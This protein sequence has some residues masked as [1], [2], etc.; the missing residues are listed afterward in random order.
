MLLT[1]GLAY[2]APA[3]DSANAIRINEVVTTG[4]V[5][6]SVE[7]YNTGTAAIDI[8]G[9]I[10][11]DDKDSSKF[12][13]PAGTTLAGRS[14]TAFDVHNAFGLGSDDEARLF[15]PDGTTLIDG[16]GWTSHSNPSWS[17]CPDGT[18]SFTQAATITLGAPNNCGGGGSPVAWP[19]SSSV[20]TA[21]A[22]NV[23]GENLSGLYEE[24]GTVLWGAQNSGKLWRLLPD[25]T[26]GWTPDTGNG[27][28][29]GKSLHF[30]G[31]SGVPDDEGVTLTSAGS[32][33]GVYVSTERDNNVPGTSRTSVL[34]YDVSA[35][36]TTLT[37]TKEWNLT[38]DLPAV[39]ANLGF[40]GITWIPDASLTGAGFIDSSTGAPYDPSRYGSHT[41]GVFF[42]GVEGS[43]MIYGYVLQDSGAF[44]RVASISSGMSAVMELQWEP[45]TSRLWVV[46]DD[47]C[48]GQHRTMK[49][50]ASGGFATTAIYNRPTGMPNL[51]NE[52][53]AISGAS[54][55]VSGAKPVYW[56]DDSD[57]SGHALRKGTITC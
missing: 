56:A 1:G 24:G 29:G 4:A 41:G 35:T 47:T 3:P 6:D 9:W 52:G 8:S 49:I 28:S 54:Q 48:N 46:C 50:N 7:L 27:W 33:G 25:G 40:E 32:A 21:D 2:A 12:T 13:I 5:N 44:T 45:Q 17:R 18:G 53:F 30:P 11:K 14:F 37:A 55:C 43:G 23:F 51:N 10:L 31:G 20:A 42:V 22:A 16:V 38:G 39:G 34:R 36:G 15:L 26:G 57:D 19:G